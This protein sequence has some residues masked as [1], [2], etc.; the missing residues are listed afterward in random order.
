VVM[1]LRPAAD[2]CRPSL[3]EQ[4]VDSAI[5]AEQLQRPVG[6]GE[7]ESRLE[8]PRVLVELGHREAPRGFGDGAEDRPSLGSRT[9]AVGQGEVIGHDGD[10]S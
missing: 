1:V 8:A 2:I 9:N 3:P 7:A 6:R 10:D 4:R 5:R